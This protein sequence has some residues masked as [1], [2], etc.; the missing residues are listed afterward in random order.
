MLT[1]SDQILQGTLY[2]SRGTQNGV[3]YLA[4]E[5]MGQPDCCIKVVSIILEHAEKYIGMKFAAWIA[6]LHCQANQGK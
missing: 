1:D 2:A 6:M 4:F 3:S 5:Y